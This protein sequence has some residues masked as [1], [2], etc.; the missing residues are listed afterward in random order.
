MNNIEEQKQ[1]EME[2][3]L[4][5]LEGEQN[6]ELLSMGIEEAIQKDGLD[7]VL[8]KEENTIHVPSY[9]IDMTNVGDIM[10]ASLEAIQTMLS[11]DG[12]TAIY[13][14]NGNMVGIIGFGQSQEL[15]SMLDTYINNVYSG[16]CQ[17]Y[18]N[19]GKGFKKIKPMDVDNITL[20]I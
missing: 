12:D 1:Q 10:P 19:S 8:L 9:L 11:E 17:I 14:K 3:A 13:M 4:P 18:K 6:Q 20:D 15:Y 2:I 16:R 7:T 5:S